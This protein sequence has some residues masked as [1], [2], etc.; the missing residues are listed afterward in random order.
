MRQVRSGDGVDRTSLFRGLDHVIADG[1]AD[2]ASNRDESSGHALGWGRGALRQRRGRSTHHLIALPLAP[3]AQ[4]QRF[5]RA[6][7]HA[8]AHTCTH[9]CAHMHAHTHTHVR[10]EYTFPPGL[11]NHDRALVHAEC[12][13]LGYSSKSHGCGTTPETLPPFAC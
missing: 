3:L 10:A 2:L 12:K 1:A 4:P 7:T 9:T 6:L 11:S 5:S 13:K 8:C